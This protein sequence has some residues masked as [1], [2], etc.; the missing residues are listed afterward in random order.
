MGIRKIKENNYPTKSSFQATGLTPSE[1]I[2]PITAFD[3]IPALVNSNYPNI[4]FNFPADRVLSSL[5]NESLVAVDRAAVIHDG[6]VEVIGDDSQERISSA[7]QVRFIREAMQQA[8][9]KTHKMKES[10]VV[11]SLLLS[12]VNITGEKFKMSEWSLV[13]LLS[14]YVMKGLIAALLGQEGV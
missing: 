2:T 9:K 5:M 14:R 6:N 8:K 13:E 1:L 3:N 12:R 11:Q 7:E 10:D 4:A